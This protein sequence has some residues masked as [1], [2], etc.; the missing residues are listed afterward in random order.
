MTRWNEKRCTDCSSRAVCNH[1]SH[2]DTFIPMFHFV[3][4][5]TI[6][7]VTLSLTSLHVK[8]LTKESITQPDGDRLDLD[9]VVKS[10]L[11]KLTSNS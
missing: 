9:I 4:L 8:R 6:E 7:L 11:T 10:S 3:N 2:S 5:Y 1:S